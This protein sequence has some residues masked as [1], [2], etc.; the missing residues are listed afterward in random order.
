M[1]KSARC[2]AVG[3][4]AR[5]Q[6]AAVRWTQREAV[7][8]LCQLV[9]G[10]RSVGPAAAPHGRKGVRGSRGRQ[11]PLGV[12]TSALV[13]ASTVGRS[14]TA[15][16]VVS[17]TGAGQR[18]RCLMTFRSTILV[19][20]TP[21]PWRPLTRDAGSR[22][23]ESRCLAPT[24]APRPSGACPERLRKAAPRQQGGVSCP[25]IPPSWGALPSRPQPSGGRQPLEP[26]GYLSLERL[27]TPPGSCQGSS[28]ASELLARCPRARVGI[29]GP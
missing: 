20:S 22:R 21:V 25:P 29:E 26:S 2:A 23:W 12:A 16:L 19:P 14:P 4:C 8:R 10:R 3:T 15:R 1:S 11:G 24:R 28:P 7:C 9:H 6:A 5:E 13:A 27:D 18:V 17:S